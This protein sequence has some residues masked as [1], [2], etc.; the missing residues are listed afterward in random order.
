MTHLI[1]GGA[2]FIGSHLAEFLIEKGESVIV[3]DDLSTGSVDNLIG[4]KGHPR[5]ECHF[6]SIF[7]KYLLAEL[8]DR[9]DAIFHL[10][11]AVGVRLIIEKPVQ[12]IET[13]ITG[14]EMV[15]HAASKKKKRV[16]VASTSEVYGK[17]SNEVF[18]EEDDLVLGATVKSRWGYAA[19]K[20]V[21]EFLA[22]AHWRE[23]GLPV[24]IGRFFNTVG[25]RQTG[26]YGMVLPT[27]VMQAIANEP[28]T[29]FG[30]GKQSR[31]FGY[32]GEVVEAMVR[33]MQ[34]PESVGQV[35]NIGNDQEITIEG[36]AHLVR[37]RVGSTSAIQYLSY[38]A[39]YESGFEDMFRRLPSLERLEKLTAFRPTM[40][41]AEIVDRVATYFSTSRPVEVVSAA[42][43]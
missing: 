11:A 31:C 28:I 32:V 40:D 39:A 24:T 22:L 29:V 43:A 21:D 26:R 25:P 13:N 33:L 5:L 10:A 16:F 35:I 27:F 36:L 17:N 15:L 14:T 20:A 18:R 9:S 1:T 19:S 6:D 42:S 3:I 37:E 4:I 34:T 12:T 8:V 38:E 23:R 7:N 30:S 2:G 41:V